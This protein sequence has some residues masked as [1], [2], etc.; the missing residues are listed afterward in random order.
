M[1]LSLYLT[2]KPG[3]WLEQNV[4]V[5]KVRKYFCSITP[6]S[7]LRPR[8]QLCLF[9]LEQDH[10]GGDDAVPRHHALQ[11]RHHLQRQE[12]IQLP[13]AVQGAVVRLREALWRPRKESRVLLAMAIMRSLEFKI[14]C[15]LTH[16]VGEEVL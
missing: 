8:M 9:L 6:A 11:R 7:P 4:T 2:R 12:G 5:G 3:N 16:R 1:Q 10:R 15:K 13:R 14:M